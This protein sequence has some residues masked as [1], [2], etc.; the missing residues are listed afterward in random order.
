MVFPLAVTV[1]QGIEQVVAVVEQQWLTMCWQEMQLAQTGDTAYVID[2]GNGEYEIYDLQWPMD[3]TWQM[4]ILADVDANTIDTTVTQ[5]GGTGNTQ[6]EQ[7]P[8]NA[9]ITC[10]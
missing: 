7:Y 5:A 3:T 9:R 1:E 6:L 10:K 2:S 4:K 8:N